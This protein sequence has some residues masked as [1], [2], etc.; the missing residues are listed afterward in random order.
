MFPSHDHEEYEEMIEWVGGKF[1]P[2][3]FIMILKGLYKMQH[4][5][6][7]THNLKSLLIALFIDIT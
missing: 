4:N 7:F 1:D 6:L 2:V 3:G 5:L